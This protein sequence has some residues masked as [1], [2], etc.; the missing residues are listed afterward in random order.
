LKTKKRGVL[1][2]SRK[3]SGR[4]KARR[5]RMKMGGTKKNKSLKGGRRNMASTTRG[6]RHIKVNRTVL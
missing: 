6:G 2:N 1:D 5:H 3:N 4:T